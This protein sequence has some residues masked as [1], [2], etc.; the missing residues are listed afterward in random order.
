MVGEEAKVISIDIKLPKIEAPKG[1]KLLQGNVRFLEEVFEQENLYSLPRPW[2]VIEDS[3]HS[4]VGCLAAIK[5]FSAHLKPEEYLVIE[6]GVLDDLGWSEQ[7]GGGPNRA[8]KEFLV[9]HP[10]EFEIDR[11]YCDM[12]GPNMTYNPNGYLKKL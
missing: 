10:N 11:E 4:Y 3:Q 6:D 7:F 9:N 1:I 5:F 2:L 12:F 8:I